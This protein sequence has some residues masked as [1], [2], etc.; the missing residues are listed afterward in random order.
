MKSNVGIILAVLFILPFI[1][2]GILAGVWM[3]KAFL[4]G[5]I[6]QGFFLL[7]F[8]VAFGGSGVGL[9][10]AL[11]AGKRRHGDLEHRKAEAPAEPWRWRKEWEGGRI[12]SGGKQ[13]LTLLWFFTTIWNAVA[14]PLIFL[15][16]DEIFGKG[17]TAALVGL[18]F[19]L[20]GI[21]LVVYA[22]RLTW[23]HLLY[24]NPV[25]VMNHLPGIVGGELSG[26]VEI[27][28]TVRPPAGFTSRLTCT[29]RTESG[30]G[31]GGSTCEEICWQ[32][33][34]K[35]IHAGISAVS[36]GT[37]VQVRF[38]IPYECEPSSV[39]NGGIS[40]KLTV[41]GAIPGVD[42]SSTFEVPVFKTVQSLPSQTEEELRK[43]ML[44]SEHAGPVPPADSGLSVQRTGSGGSEFVVAAG[45]NPAA[46]AGLGIFA[47]IWTGILVLVAVGGGP[48][49]ISVILG[50]F[51]LLFLAG[52]VQFM[53]TESRIVVEE[54][55]VSVR[56]YV[57]GLMFGKRV[58]CAEI[59]HVHLNVGAQAGT[60][61]YHSV[62]LVKKSGSSLTAGGLIRDK[63]QADWLA[64]A[65][66]QAIAAQQPRP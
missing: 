66:T 9:I 42:F 8:S 11:V 38:R 35:G 22:L 17:N 37:T 19:P 23:S 25:F 18:L 51:D 12:Q 45:R 64:E 33:E 21:G 62:A 57:F 55:H 26:N 54:G 32:D 14:F 40:W 1:G 46:A 58:P 47:A 63:R 20:T 65:L 41:V 48:I 2:V 31:S 61:V 6:S 52:V 43:D 50:V 34:Q 27:G 44:G 7:A 5:D 49:F 3:I 60:T 10:V 29:R 16:R 36:G 15:L 39:D 56:W 24:G 28:S 30:S 13:G 59:E 4:A 53:F